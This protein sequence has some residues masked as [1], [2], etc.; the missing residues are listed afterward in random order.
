MK[1]SAAAP[2]IAAI[3]LAAG[4]SARMGTNKLLIEFEGKPFLLHAIKAAVASK[5]NPVIAVTGHDAENVEAA[6]GGFPV[7]TV[8]NEH[9]DKGLSTSLRRGLEA[10]PAGCNGALIMLADMPHISAVLIDSLIEMFSLHGG[11]VICVPVR[12]G[13]QGNP[14]LWSR[15]FFPEMSALKG[16]RGAK[17][18]LEKYAN[19]IH[20]VEVA[21]DGPFTDVDTPAALAKLIGRV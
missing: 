7:I 17:S 10:V 1:H 16:D 6:L 13:R 2:K 3:V 9:Y 11:P 21:D 15:N 4:A 12:G 8:R 19:L 18:L 5:A 14:I 20:E